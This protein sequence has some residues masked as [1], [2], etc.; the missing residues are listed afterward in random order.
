[1]ARFGLAD[2][3]TPITVGTRVEEVEL[4][5]LFPSVEGEIVQYYGRIGSGKT[6]NATADI[7]ADLQA[8]L[9]VYANW[10]LNWH[11]FDERDSLFYIIRSM[12]FPWTKRFYK[13]PKENLKFID[14]D[15]SFIDKFEKITDAKVY[16]D[17]GHV[18]FDSYEMA[19]MSL[20]KRK[21]VLHTRH[22]NRSIAII[23]QRPTAVHV[24]MRANVNIFY[25]CEK[26][27]MLRFPFQLI[28]GLPLIIF[29][30]T[31]F[32][33]ISGETVDET[34]P[35]GKKYY[36]AKRQVM[37]AYDTKYL[38]GTLPPSQRVLFEAYDLSFSDKLSRF[39]YLVRDLIRLKPDEVA[40]GKIP[41][42]SEEFS[43]SL[44]VESASATIKNGERLN[45]IPVGDV[46]SRKKTQELARKRAAYFAHLREAR[47]KAKAP[48]VVEQEAIP[49]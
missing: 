6:Y 44:G 3:P 46:L 18:A 28:T 30:R 11:G 43:R 41:S 12:L 13:F 14:I 22:F 4:M 15:D 29:K 1:M 47:E 31:E 9:V 24:S 19:K 21:A 2:M 48:A 42:A 32:Q 45:T 23:S 36:R 20:Q 26:I 5:D 33:D 39:M 17:E 27:F 40:D 49:F 8:G 34:E 37:E 16:L 25:K 35:L 38:R 10:K 7:L